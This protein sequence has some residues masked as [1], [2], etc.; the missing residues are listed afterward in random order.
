VSAPPGRETF[1]E[2]EAKRRER[3]SI[4]AGRDAING[5]IHGEHPPAPT[6]AQREFADLG[7]QLDEVNARLDQGS[8]GAAPA[9]PLTGN[10]LV[11]DRLR[12]AFRHEPADDDTETGATDA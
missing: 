12:R 6:P 5:F 1:A 10:D 7:H 9:A 3:Q 11:N 4:Q 8:R 2:H